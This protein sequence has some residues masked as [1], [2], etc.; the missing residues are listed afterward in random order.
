MFKSQFNDFNNKWHL[1]LLHGLFWG[2]S[3]IPFLPELF[4]PSPNAPIDLFLVFLSFFYSFFLF[5]LLF[6]PFIYHCPHPFSLPLP[7]PNPQLFLILKKLLKFL[8]APN[9]PESNFTQ[10]NGRIAPLFYNFGCFLILIFRCSSIFLAPDFNW[11]W[12]RNENPTDATFW[13]HTILFVHLFFNFSFFHHCCGWVFSESFIVPPLFNR[14]RSASPESFFFLFRFVL[15][16]P[17]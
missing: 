15:P 10:F 12:C 8:P 13:F 6:F 2:D 11:S 16:I 1:F 5:S 4:F 7:Y 17:F 9:T 3:Y 14:L